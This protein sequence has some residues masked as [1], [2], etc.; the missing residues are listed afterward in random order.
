LAKEKPSGDNFETMLRRELHRVPALNTA[1]C[2]A[3]E[4]L[5]AYYDRT[6]SRGERNRV[7]SHL[8]SCARCQTMMASMARADDS[9]TTRPRETAGGFFWLTRVLAPVTMLGIVIVIAI[10]IRNRAQP[11]P[12]TLAMAS[13]AV[14]RKLELAER[15][16][17]APP[18]F[19]ANASKPA[20]P[21]IA[22]PP[23][24]GTSHQEYGFQTQRASAPPAAVADLASAAQSRMQMQSRAAGSMAAGAAASGSMAAGS[25]A[26]GS[27]A[28]TAKAAA[29]ANIVYSPDRS[30]TWRFGNAGT[31]ARWTSATG[32]VAQPSGVTTNLLAASAPS[33]DVGWMAGKSGTIIR[34]LDGGAHWQLITPPSRKNFVAITSTDSNNASIV[35]ADGARFST[36]D[37]GVTWSSP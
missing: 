18:A 15:A 6:L 5:A 17:A 2:V 29:A 13:P 20:A 19:E 14:S 31:I 11:K 34:T 24:A 23:V 4:V 25:M 27:I 16:P 28:M 22:A 3:P 12:E 36:R 9:D 1:D 35:G 10:G 7:E 30:V 26:P 37:G 32:W 8:G 21:S 33:N